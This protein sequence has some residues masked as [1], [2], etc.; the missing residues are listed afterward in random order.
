MKFLTQ[1]RNLRVIL[2]LALCLF[3][4]AAFAQQ[5]GNATLPIPNISVNMGGA[6]PKKGE[7][8]STSD[9]KSVV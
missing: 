9:R 1:G 5:A 6:A 3:G 7:E 8:V 4:V 2:I